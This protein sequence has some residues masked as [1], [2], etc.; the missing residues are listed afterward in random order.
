MKAIIVALLVVAAL[1]QSKIS[2]VGI[3]PLPAIIRGTSSK[4]Y[5][6]GKPSSNFIFKVINAP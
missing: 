1:S 4:I 3:A 5:L 2:S 6:D